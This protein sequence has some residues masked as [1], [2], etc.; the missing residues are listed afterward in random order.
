MRVWISVV[1]NFPSRPSSSTYRP[2]FYATFQKANV[3]LYIIQYIS[4]DYITPD[5]KNWFPTIIGFKVGGVLEASSTYLRE[6]INREKGL[7]C[8]KGFLS[9][10][11][12]VQGSTRGRRC[13]AIESRTMVKDSTD[14]NH[15]LR[16][17]TYCAW[18]IPIKDAI[19][20]EGKDNGRT[21]YSLL[22]IYTK[23]VRKAR[24]VFCID[25]C[26][27]PYYYSWNKCGC[28]LPPWRDTST[29]FLACLKLQNLL[30]CPLSTFSSKEEEI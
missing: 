2:Q 26:V 18:V 17:A 19:G 30:A 15:E 8:E 21:I 4:P 25:C 7:L 22:S 1:S 14:C 24:P 27:T 5:S 12:E 11:R 29:T 6:K 20:A 13:M 3:I 23:D 9:D 16:I 10:T 28:G